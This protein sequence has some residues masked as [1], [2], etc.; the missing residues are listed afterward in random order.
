MHIRLV[1]KKIKEQKIVPI[2]ELRVLLN[3]KLQRI[4][5]LVADCDIQDCKICRGIK[6]KIGI[7]A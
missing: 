3:P 1:A 2:V 4:L 5:S 7:K 6:E